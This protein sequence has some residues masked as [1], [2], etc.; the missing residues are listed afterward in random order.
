MALQNIIQHLRARFGKYERL[1]DEEH[2]ELESPSYKRCV[3]K[4]FKFPRFR[5][6]TVYLILSN[7][8]ILGVLIHSIRPL[9]TLLI[10]NNELFAINF[11][12]DHAAQ[13]DAFQ[14]PDGKKI[15][16]ILHQTAPNSSIPEIWATS[17]QSCKEAYSDFEYKLWTDEGAREFLK[18]EFPWYLD[19]WDNYPFPIQRADAIRYFVLYHFGGI[20]MDMDTYCNSSFPVDQIESLPGKDHALFK[21][22]L[23]TG[24]TNDFLISTARHPAFAS[25]VSRLASSHQATR[26]W[27]RLQPYAAIMLSTG[28]LF[29][30]LAVQQ[31]LLGQPILPSPTIHIMDPAVL[32]HYMVD[33]ETATWHQSD[34]QV[35]MWLGDRPWTWFSLG[36]IG[37]IAGIYTFNCVLSRTTTTLYRKLL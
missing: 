4:R 25:A 35:L 18:E 36:I 5:K 27:A 29:L 24:I 19:T 8:I 3:P 26:L 16:R 32:D 14:R 33:F 37:V 11:S 15:P 13:P 12:V 20:Y 21:S 22:T 6:L 1:Y 17:Q 9:I 34:A 30:T 23:P 2:I 7:L 28:P 31:Y 10:R